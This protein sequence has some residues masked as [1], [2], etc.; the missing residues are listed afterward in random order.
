MKN[1]TS[2]APHICLNVRANTSR[3]CLPLGRRIARMISQ[4]TNVEVPP[5]SGAKLNVDE[6][7][8]WV[9]EEIACT[10]SFVKLYPGRCDH[11]PVQ[12]TTTRISTRNGIHELIAWRRLPI[13]R[14]T[15]SDVGA[16]TRGLPPNP[17]IVFGRQIFTKTNSTQNEI[18]A[19]LRSGRYGPR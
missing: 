3:I 10:V 5:P 2:S 12:P 7:G 17:R 8:V 11:G 19:P 9:T 16:I 15:A 1:A 6:M 14:A 13:S 4:E 18:S